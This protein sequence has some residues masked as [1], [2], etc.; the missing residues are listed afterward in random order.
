MA[1]IESE[2]SDLHS[3]LLGF[4]APRMGRGTESEYNQSMRS[5]EIWSTLAN[6]KGTKSNVSDICTGTESDDVPIIS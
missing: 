3:R 1:L 6:Y 5:R 2:A 4:Y